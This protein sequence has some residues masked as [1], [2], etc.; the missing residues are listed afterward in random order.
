MS[1]HDANPGY[2][3]PRYNP[4]CPFTAEELGRLYVAE[5]RSLEDV[6]ALASARLGQT[7][8]KAKVRD[9]LQRFS[10]P[11]RTFSEAARLRR[12]KMPPPQEVS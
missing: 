10:L 1:V 3:A 9:W 8:N 4:P 6:A 11:V 12:A 7:I 2:N 5:G